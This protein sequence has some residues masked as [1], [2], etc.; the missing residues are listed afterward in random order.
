MLSKFSLVFY[1]TP[2]SLPGK[3]LVS[4]IGS[5]TLLA[6][7]EGAEADEFVYI[8]GQLAS[9]C[10]MCMGKVCPFDFYKNFIRKGGSDIGRGCVCVFS[11]RDVLDALPYLLIRKKVLE[12]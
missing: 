10:L 11:C 3:K 5:A 7:L 4:A 6:A 2:R 12:D 8:L 9:L 1:E